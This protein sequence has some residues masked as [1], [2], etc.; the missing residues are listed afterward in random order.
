MFKLI[1]TDIAFPERYEH[2]ERKIATVNDKGWDKVGDFVLR[3]GIDLIPQEGLQEN[4]CKCEANLIFVCGQ[5]TSGKCAPLDS[6]V[7][8]PNGFVLMGD[9]KVGDIVCGSDG[10]PQ[11][12]LQI[13]EQPKKQMYRFTMADGATV[14]SSAEHLWAIRESRWK[15]SAIHTIKTTEEIIKDFEASKGKPKTGTVR[16]ICFPVNGP[17]QFN[18]RKELKIHPYV[19]GALIGDGCFRLDGKRVSIATPDTDIIN[20]IK[21]LGYDVY[22]TSSQKAIEYNVR[23]KAF[24]S[25]LSDYGLVG[26]LS[27]DKFIP[28][29]Y[30]YASIEDREELLHG[31]F[32]T[33]GSCSGSSI[34]YSTTSEK[35]A[36]QVTF[37][38]RSLGYICKCQS[39]ITKFTYKGEK[40]EGHKSFR[41]TI[42]TDNGIP[43]FSLSRKQNAFRPNPNHHG[44]VPM[45]YLKS[46]EKTRITGC[47]CI[48]VSN[49]DHLYIMDDFVVTHNTFGMMLKGL[50]GI[51]K[52][53]Y[54]G[55]LINVRKL[56]SAKGTSMYRDA[57]FV[58]GEFS[59]CEINT[60][61]LPTFAWST[62]N[63]AIQMIHANFNPENPK[64]WDEFQ[65][66]IKKQQAAY[67]AIDEATAIEQFRMFAYMFS[68]NRDASG[69]EPC[70]VLSFNPKYGHWTT[71]FLITGGY[72]DPKTWYII[73][74]MDGKKRYFYIKGDDPTSVVWGDSKEEVVEAAHI[75]ISDDD[76]AAGLTE[77]D[78]VKSF[79]LLTGSAAGNR[80]LV[81]ATR[82]QSV[83]NLHNVGAAQRAVLAEAYFGPTEDES[84]G[85]AD[86]DFRAMETNPRNSDENMYATMDVSGGKLESDDNLML[87]FQGNC[88]VGVETFRGDPKQLLDWIDQKLDHWG[89]P[90]QNFAFDATG[91]GYYLTAFKEG[92]PITPN[93]TPMQ[94]YDEQGNPVT[95]EQYFNLRSQLLAKTEVLFKTGFFCT[96][97][98]LNMQIPYG[99]KGGKRRII[100]I[101]YNEKNVFI[102]GQKN[103]K[104]L[105]RSKDEYIARF[106]ESPGLMD[107]FTYRAVFEL[108]ARPKKP[109]EKEIDDSAYSGLFQDYGGGRSV[110][111]I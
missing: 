29:E 56:D 105:Y 95:I 58:W 110:V 89:V 15:L 87:I 48:Y 81:A 101:L 98:D 54:T 88:W 25:A 4:L 83:A 27:Y 2:V 32:D 62:W 20:R 79:V 7:L 96:T 34:E 99:K 53:G 16:N 60:G 12:V 107:P 6:K 39:R 63:N 109:P 92:I 46:I 3:D 37:L 67:I 18:S 35:L 76:R 51:G 82:G 80:K 23:G 100:D 68:R 71:Q 69:V 72:I 22:Q 17:I 14:E 9:L 5:A 106:H 70:M 66:Y 28:K 43:V 8:T 24:F 59:H 77:A 74:E 84:V 40:K 13:F 55:R 75:R 52:Y 49:P 36:E 41:I 30:L 31:L 38:A 73:P 97:L 21:E 78:M 47:R 103:K 50:D 19:L 91:I 26:K 108:D 11:T 93:K 104:I 42:S 44:F 85:V 102:K 10:K 90:R 94:E 65:E 45:H 86:A 64:E 111:W 57:S 33:D 61:E 1:H